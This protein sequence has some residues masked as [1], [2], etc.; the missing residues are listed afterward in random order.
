MSKRKPKTGKAPEC[1]HIWISNS[2]AG[3]L[4]RWRMNRQL[5]NE[6]LMNV[7]CSE[8]NARTWMT[9]DQWNDLPE[10]NYSE[11]GPE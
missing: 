6:P 5:S 1:S 3:G 8:C 10:A 11:A 2:G 4:P 9:N 7:R